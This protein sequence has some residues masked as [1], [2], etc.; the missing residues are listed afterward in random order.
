MMNIEAPK[1]GKLLANRYSTAAC[2]GCGQMIPV[3]E[4][5]AYFGGSRRGWRVWH[6]RCVAADQE[7]LGILR[8]VSKA[9][10]AADR[11]I[12]RDAN[13]DRR[14]AVVEAYRAVR[15]WLTMPGMVKLRDLLIAEV[16]RCGSEDVPEPPPSTS[17]S[18]PDLRLI[19][20]GAGR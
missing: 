3:G 11:S 17:R 13:E 16:T 18:K 6:P 12:M 2:A 10:R 5:V 4:V 14:T 1:D 19:A 9:V 15:D 8:A 20:G 7:V